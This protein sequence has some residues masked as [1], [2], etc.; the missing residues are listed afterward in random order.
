CCGLTRSSPSGSNAAPRMATRL[1]PCSRSSN[2]TCKIHPK[3][4]PKLHPKR[5]PKMHRTHWVK[6]PLSIYTPP[7]T[8]FYPVQKLQSGA[9]PFQSGLASCTGLST[10]SHNA[11][12]GRQS[13]APANQVWEPIAPDWTPYTGLI[14]LREG[15]YTQ[16]LQLCA[17]RLE[18]PHRTPTL[19]ACRSN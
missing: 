18:D 4:W 7:H 2:A 14:P 19:K 3:M 17:K 15:V 1:S 8:P 12:F 6:D 10:C 5:P 11:S 16:P 9:I 13:G